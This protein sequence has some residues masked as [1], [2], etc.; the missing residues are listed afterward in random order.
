MLVSRE[1]L[2]VLM[3]VDA[4]ILGGFGLFGYTVHRVPDDGKGLE[5]AG[6][7]QRRPSLEA[8]EQRAGG[9]LLSHGS[10]GDRDLRKTG[11]PAKLLAEGAESGWRA[12]KL[13]FAA[14]DRKTATS[15]VC[16][17]HR[18]ACTRAGGRW[19][20]F[21]D[22]VRPSA[23]HHRPGPD[24]THREP[25]PPARVPEYWAIA[26]TPRYLTPAKTSKPD[27]EVRPWTRGAPSAPLESK[28]H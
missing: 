24:P 22:A 23:M 16:G 5:A 21:T 18:I 15:I 7:M 19:W 11:M 14:A 26:P 8:D 2:D 1:I 20:T 4:P 27:G 13:Q 25:L 9:D 3:P 17:A 6:E 10:I 12:G 28:V